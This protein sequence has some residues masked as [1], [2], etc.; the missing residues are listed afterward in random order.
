MS[1]LKAKKLKW[2]HGVMDKE[3]IYGEVAGFEVATIH[4]DKEYD[5]HLPVVL[6]MLLPTEHGR[7]HYPDIAYAKQQ[8]QVELDMFINGIME[9]EDE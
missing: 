3:Y 5:K 2:T 6:S 8:A 1:E 4:P 7:G 9:V